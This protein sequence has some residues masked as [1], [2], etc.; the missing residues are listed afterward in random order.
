MIIASI[1]NFLTRVQYDFGF[2]FELLNPCK[3]WSWLRLIA[4]QPSVVLPSSYDEAKMRG[5]LVY[6]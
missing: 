2:D 3:G 5:G 4:T 6:V 1:F